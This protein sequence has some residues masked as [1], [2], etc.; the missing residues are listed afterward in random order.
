MTKH[1]RWRFIRPGEAVAP[2]AAGIPATTGRRRRRPRP[3]PPPGRRRSRSPGRPLGGF[4]GVAST[5][6]EKSLRDLQRADDAT[7]SGCSSPASRGSSAGPSGRRC[8]GPGGAFPAARPP[9]TGTTSAG[10]SVPSP[11][12][13]AAGRP[14]SAPSSGWRRPAGAAGDWRRRR[15]RLRLRHERRRG[16]ARHRRAGGIGTVPGRRRRRVGAAGRAPGVG[17]GIRRPPPGSAI[18]PP[19]A[20]RRRPPRPPGRPRPPPRDAGS[21]VSGLDPGGGPNGRR[22]PR[23]RPGPAAAD[24]PAPPRPSRRPPRQGLDSARRAGSATRAKLTPRPSSTERTV[25]AGVRPWRLSVTS[26]RGAGPLVDDL[27]PGLA[28]QTVEDL[29]ERGGGGGEVDVAAGDANGDLGRGGG[30]RKGQHDERGRG[31]HEASLRPPVRPVKIGE[32]IAL[33]RSALVRRRASSKAFRSPGGI[34]SAGGASMRSGSTK[35]PSRLM[36]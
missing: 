19:G 9:S 3:P 33:S 18:S 2:G 36:R 7:T 6:T 4:Q 32:R 5:S 29:G 10:R 25:S 12:R 1:G 34:G 31:S 8:R 15:E 22:G 24:E 35:R 26:C 13:A 30:R 16:E 23:G 27:H 11:V 14:A 28:R 20:A 17:A 21:T